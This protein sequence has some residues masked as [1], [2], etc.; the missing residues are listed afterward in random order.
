MKKSLDFCEYNYIDEDTVEF[1]VPYDVLV[2]AEK[3]VLRDE[4]SEESRTFE[5]DE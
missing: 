1:I 3:I 2:N 4:D 5:E